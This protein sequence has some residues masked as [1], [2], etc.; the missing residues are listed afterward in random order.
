MT[1]GEEQVEQHH[2]HQHTHH[3]MLCC[4]MP[5]LVSLFMSRVDAMTT[6]NTTVSPMVMNND[7]DVVIDTITPGQGLAQRQ[8][9][10]PAK[11]NHS[12]NMFSMQQVRSQPMSKDV[13]PP[14]SFSY[15]GYQQGSGQQ[16][17]HRIQEGEEEQL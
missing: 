16:G 4:G 7:D 3:N 8:G 17:Y 11:T 15:G 1:I 6:T 10:G 9:L 12:L 2:A 13:I 5:Y 14:P